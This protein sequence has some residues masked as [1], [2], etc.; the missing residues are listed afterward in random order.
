MKRKEETVK[1]SIQQP[2]KYEA[3]WLRAPDYLQKV[4]ELWQTQKH[5]PSSLNNS[6]ETL[7]KISDGLKCWSRNSFGS[8][9][10]EIKNLEKRLAAIRKQNDGIISYKEERDIEK[11]LCELFEREEIMARQR[12]RI[13][14]LKEGDRNTAFFHARATARRRTNRIK[15]LKRADGSKCNEQKEIMRMVHDFYS[16]LFSSEQYPSLHEVLEAIPRKVDEEMNESL[17]QEYSNE[18]IKRDLFQMGPMKAPGPD[19]FP[20]FFYQKHWDLLEQDICEAV[21]GFLT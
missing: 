14:W 12:S 2:F 18:E 7:K 4:E 11:R 10:K 15:I 21:R 17:M 5:G 16:N 8:V 3:A 19:G 6:W 1:L 9:S 20:T 13:D